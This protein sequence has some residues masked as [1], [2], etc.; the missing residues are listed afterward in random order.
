MVGRRGTVAR[1]DLRQASGR[2]ESD[3]DGPGG[4]MTDMSYSFRASRWSAETAYRQD[5]DALRWTSGRGDGQVAY[6]EIRKVAIYKVRYFGSRATFW[7]CDLTDAR[8]R[9]IRLQAAHCAD[10]GEIEDRSATYIPFVKQLESRIAVANPSAV[11]RPGRH[12]IAAVDAAIGWL[13]VWVLRLIRLVDL[14]RAAGATAWLMRRI[15]PRLKGHRVARENLVAAYPEKPADEIER[16]LG[17]MW[18]NL[19]RVFVEYAHIDRIWD[20]DPARADCGRIIFEG[21][22]RSNYLAF[23]EERGPRVF[24]GAH[25]ANW[26]FLI[27]AT[28]SPVE[29]AVIYR[30]AKVA[31]IDRELA[32]IR[33]QSGCGLIPASGKALFAIRNL[34]RR[35]GSVGFLVDEHFPGGIDVTFFGRP[36][37]A[38]PI[39][40][41]LAR[42]YDCLIQGGRV[43]R[44]PGERFRIEITE[45][46]AA[47]RDADGKVDVAATMRMITGII[48]GWV[49]ENPEQWLWL[50]RRW[51]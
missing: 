17:G 14:E 30:P 13:F 43:V 15:G 33:T 11:F 16:I 41:E 44:Q 7:R 9:R 10:G 34:L 48:E 4:P 3:D 23:M 18:D 39:F 26:E 49:R 27:W 20:F 21:E 47:P 25:L 8:G 32:R 24:F 22:S 35:R 12:W 19:G 28:R 29:A 6:A 38:T 5:R 37:T 36:C 51:R 1:R 42:R 2:I 40:A 46:L 45:P 31:A 50:Q